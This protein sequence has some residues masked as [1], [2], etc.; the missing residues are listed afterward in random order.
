MRIRNVVKLKHLLYRGW[1]ASDANMYVWM[2]LERNAVC[3]L[4][5][6]AWYTYS[7]K[8]TDTYG[9]KGH[10]NLDLVQ[11]SVNCLNNK[12]T[13]V[14]QV[15]Y[16]IRIFSDPLHSPWT[17]HYVPAN[18]WLN[19]PEQVAHW[20]LLFV[21]INKVCGIILMSYLTI[22]G[23]I[24]NLVDFQALIKLSCIVHTFSTSCRL[25]SPIAAGFKQWMSLLSWGFFWCGT[26]QGMQSLFLV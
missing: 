6:T 9:Y 22:L 3:L 12:K 21:F 16:S 10:F 14:S 11:L 23:Q 7:Q 24:I 19:F 25:I 17:L 26:E 5:Y 1:P 8:F 2:S 15:F 4:N 20:H 18:S 13:L